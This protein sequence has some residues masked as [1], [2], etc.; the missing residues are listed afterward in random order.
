MAQ[1]KPRMAKMRLRSHEYEAHDSPSEAHEIG[2]KLCGGSVLA[3]MGRLMTKSEEQGPKNS[4]KCYQKIGITFS[5]GARNKR[6]FFSV[7]DFWPFQ[8]HF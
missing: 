4:K 2:L 1:M 7:A 6:Q 3:K 5:G 8:S